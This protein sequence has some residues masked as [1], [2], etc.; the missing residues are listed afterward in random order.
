V[1]KSRREYL[2]KIPDCFF[3]RRLPSFWNTNSPTWAAKFLFMIG[4]QQVMLLAHRTDEEVAKTLLGPS[5]IYPQLCQSQKAI[6]HG[7]IDV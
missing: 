3:S 5:L 4:G 7:F 2:A 1:A 6:L